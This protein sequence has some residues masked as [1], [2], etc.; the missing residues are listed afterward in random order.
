MMKTVTT[1]LAIRMMKLKDQGMSLEDIATELG[2]SSSTVDRVVNG[3]GRYKEFAKAYRAGEKCELQDRRKKGRLIEEPREEPQEEIKPE[4]PK[5]ESN[6]YQNIIQEGAILLIARFTESV[7]ENTVLKIE[8]DSNEKAFAEKTEEL[9]LFEE[10]NARLTNENEKLMMLNKRF[11]SEINVDKFMEMF[12]TPEMKEF[13][14][15]ME[16]SRSMRSLKAA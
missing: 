13:R 10:E 3:K 2:S 1:K 15:L 16:K 5:E 11:Q 8:L 9:A 6:F 12:S 7:R 14:D 4:T